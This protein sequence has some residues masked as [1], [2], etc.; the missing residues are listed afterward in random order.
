M[1][2]SKKE[3]L[4]GVLFASPFLIG[5]IVFFIAPFIVSIFY[6]FTF[7]TGGISFVGF[8]NY[9]EV[10]QS[11]AFKLASYNTLRFIG[12][13]VPL[14]MIMATIFSLMLQNKFGGVS[15]F[16]SVFLYPLVIP[17]ASTVMVFQIIFS[18]SGIINTIYEW[19]GIPMQS[20][21]N[22]DKAFYVLILLYIW[23]NCG[24]NIVLLLAGLNSIP[25]DFYE[26]AEIEGATKWQCFRK[27]TMPIMMPNF[28]FVFVISII[29]S[30]KSF[31]EAFL[32]SGT[33]PHK[34]I[35]MMQHFMNN[36]FSNLNYQR[37]SVAALLVFIVI[38]A[39]VYVLFRLRKKAGD[40]QL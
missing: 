5:F 15:F 40:I 4:T 23:K 35:Y 38:F 17:I 18:N 28:F 14:I 34:S 36:N 13:G 39:F 24:Y 8:N 19:L 25:H 27:I 26:V 9:I 7:G 16:R 29:N 2:I 33:M 30:F 37:L 32:L 11:S 20:F 3:S 1:T 22:S 31:R 21:I 10:F 12:I 6:T